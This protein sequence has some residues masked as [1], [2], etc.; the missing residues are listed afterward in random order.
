MKKILINLF[1]FF[2]VFK[3]LMYHSLI[4]Q[5]ILTATNLF[6]T[7]VFPSLFPFF[8]I[9]DLLINYNMVTYINRIFTPITKYVFH[10]N[11]NTAYILFMSMLSGCPSSSKYTSELYEKGLIN[12]IDANKVIMF[13]HFCNPLF[14]LSMVPNKSLLVLFC[15]YISNLY[16]EI[17]IYLIQALL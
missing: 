11:P 13:S 16:L 8:I 4:Q 2:I 5:D 15:H 12:D 3:L 7:K 10:L 14:I 9:S 1:L 17:I 6:I